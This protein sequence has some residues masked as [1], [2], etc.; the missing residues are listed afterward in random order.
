MQLTFLCTDN[1]P[2]TYVQSSAKLS[3]TGLRWVGELADYHFSIHYHPGKA[4]IDADTMSGLPI[5]EFMKHCTVKT[6]PDAIKV[7]FSMI[8]LKQIES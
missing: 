8:R 3:A 2:L 6:T 5:E 1:N 7:T 4:H